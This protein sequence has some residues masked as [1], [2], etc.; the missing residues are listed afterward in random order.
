MPVLADA[1]G[2]DEHE[3]EMLHYSILAEYFGTRYDARFGREWPARTSSE[4][5]TKEFSDYMEW[6]VR[7]AAMEHNA[8]IPLP[9]E[10]EAA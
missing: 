5:S 10:S 9:N 7:W 2:Y 3:H 6:L 1:L 8:I 4:L